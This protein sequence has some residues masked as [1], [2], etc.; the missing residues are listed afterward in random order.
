MKFSAICDTPFDS[1]YMSSEDGD[2]AKEQYLE[3][4]DT[5]LLPNR[6]TFLAFNIEKNRLYTFL[7][8]HVYGVEKFSALWNVMIFVFTMFHGQSNVE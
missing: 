6:E 2:K 1:H 3:F 7:T 4:L 8:A 5:V